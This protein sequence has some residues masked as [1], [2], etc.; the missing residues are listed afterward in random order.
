MLTQTKTINHKKLKLCKHLE[1]SENNI[2]KYI[3]IKIISMSKC[4][5][6]MLNQA[7]E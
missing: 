4:A 6:V 3:P 1:A 5:F 2:Q 7:T